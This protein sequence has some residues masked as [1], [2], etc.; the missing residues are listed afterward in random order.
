MF[1]CRCFMSVLISCL[2]T[3]SFSKSLIGCLCIAPLTPNYDAEPDIGRPRP[4]VLGG[5]G[6]DI[7]FMVQ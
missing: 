1:W 6:C 3:L 5:H 2:G 7:I 4:W